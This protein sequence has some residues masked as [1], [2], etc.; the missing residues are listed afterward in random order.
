MRTGRYKTLMRPARTR[1]G[2]YRVCRP[3]QRFLV[4]RQRGVFIEQGNSKFYRRGKFQNPAAFDDFKRFAERNNIDLIREGIREKTFQTK[5]FAVLNE[6]STISANYSQ[7]KNKE[8]R[9]YCYTMQAKPEAEEN[10]PEEDSN[11]PESVQTAPAPVP[12]KT[13]PEED[14]PAVIEAMTEE[15]DSKKHNENETPA[16]F[17]NVPTPEEDAQTL[18]RLFSGEKIECD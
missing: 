14:T 15:A 10:T 12:E 16:P 8:G 1:E 5:F 6:D 17:E 11:A 7:R 4:D 9:Y 3:H 2:V 18:E 13:T